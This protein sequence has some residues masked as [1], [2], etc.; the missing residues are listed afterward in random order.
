LRREGAGQ[1]AGAAG[2]VEHLVAGLHVGHRHGV[3]LPGAVQAADSR[4]FIRSYFCATESKTPRTRA[5][6]SRSS[7]VS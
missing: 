6:F 7:T 1:V 5:A 3:G 4:S 2:D